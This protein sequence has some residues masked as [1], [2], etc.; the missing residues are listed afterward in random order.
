MKTPRILCLPNGPYYLVFGEEPEP[1]PFLRRADGSSCST[2]RAVAL[3]RCGQSR[4][5]PLCDGTHGTVGFSDARLEPRS[6][7]R[8]TTYAGPKIAIHD[9]RGLCAHIGHCT[10]GLSAVFREEGEPWIDAAGATAEAIA[11]TVR[12]CPS[13]ALGY[14]VDGVEATDRDAPPAVTA[15]R[16]GPYAVT[17]GIELVGVAFG[18]GASREH[19][20]LCRCGASRNKPFCDGS[21]WEVGFRDPVE[22]P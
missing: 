20:T 2:V 17:G 22:S 11:A 6:P 15:L 10:E 16:D 5:K 13:G 21:H 19:Y 7:D 3:C 9:N 1:V 12:R 14:S 4:N 8:R 18:E